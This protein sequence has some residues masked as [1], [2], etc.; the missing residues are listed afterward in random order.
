MRKGALIVCGILCAGF[1]WA[2]AAA[3][4]GRSE[5]RLGAAI[6][7]SPLVTECIARYEQR[8]PDVKITAVY[9]S[10]GSIRRQI[11]NGAPPDIFLSASAEHMDVLEKKGLLFSGSRRDIVTNRLVLIVPRE[12]AETLSFAGLGD[13]SVTRVAIGE[14][15]TVPAGKYA[16][17]ILAHAGV[18]EEVLKKVVYAKNVRQ[19]LYYVESGEADAGIVYLSEVLGSE[20]A[21]VVDQGEEGMHDPVVYPGAVLQECRDHDAAVAFLRWLTGGEAQALFEQYGFGVP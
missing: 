19:V 18:L 11:E 2:G 14:P 1:L 4:E 20:N 3:D 12:G 16:T 7:L 6:S 13:S 15:A 8:V 10:S 5:I 9:G 21:R 17:Q